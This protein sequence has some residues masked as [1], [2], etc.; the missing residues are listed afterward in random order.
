MQMTEKKR[1]PDSWEIRAGVSDADLRRVF[2]WARN[3][4]YA[5][6]IDL[7]RE[8]LRID[9]PPSMSSFQSWYAWYS[10]L[11]SAE[12]VHKAIADS[13]AIA[14]L[15]REC[16]DVSDAMVAALEAEASAAILSGDN[17]RMK[18]VV[19]L[20]LKAR[21]ARVQDKDTEI[22]LRRLALIEEQASQAKQRLEG[23]ASKGGLT[24]ETI[25]EIEQ[26]ARLL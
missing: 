18:L 24:P 22:K 2:G 13:A 11:E 14:D 12:R 3:L 16:G 26:A 9:P 15:A 23:L 8:E 21:G 20:A 10:R 17:D 4:G 25:E 19:E 1:R 5:R 6:A 7:V